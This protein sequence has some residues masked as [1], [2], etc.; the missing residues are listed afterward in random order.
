M[1]FIKKYNHQILKAYP[2]IWISG[3]HI[4]LP[5]LLTLWLLSYIVGAALKFDLAGLDEG[6]YSSYT[7]AKSIVNSV[8]ALLVL[9]LLAIAIFFVSRQIKYNNIR[10]HHRIPYSFS[11]L[12]FALYFV[13]F[14]GLLYAISLFDQGLIRSNGLDEIKWLTI[15]FKLI[16]Y[17]LIA[18]GFSAVLYIVCTTSKSDFGAALVRLFLLGPVVSLISV[19]IFFITKGINIDLDESVMRIIFLV[20]VLFVAYLAFLSKKTHSKKVVWTFVLFFL[21]IPAFFVITGI[22]DM[23]EFDLKLLFASLILINT[24]GFNEIFKRKIAYPKGEI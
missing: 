13:T 11:L 10:V 20:T 17:S 15:Q 14:F 12:Y 7:Q 3:L 1:N 19:F 9:I 21:T 23:K 8:R 6:Y 2:K 16:D 4:I 22:Y 5:L 24:L 18:L